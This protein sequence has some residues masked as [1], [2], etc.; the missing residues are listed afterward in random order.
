MDI[1]FKQN[2]WTLR[3]SK[4]V[5]LMSITRNRFEEFWSPH[6][7]HKVSQYTALMMMRIMC[8]V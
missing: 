8:G 6:P 5:D 2:K 1:I 4:T 7:H 3:K